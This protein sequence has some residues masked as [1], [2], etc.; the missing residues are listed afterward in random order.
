MDKGSG[1][2]LR[3]R[4]LR[5][6][7][8]LACGLIPWVSMAAS[9]E[10]LQVASRADPTPHYSPLVAEIP[11]PDLLRLRSAHAIVVDQ[12]TREI[13]FA[14]DAD[15]P[16]PIASITKLM[17]AMVNLDAELDLDERITITDGDVDTL[18]GTSS[19]LHIGDAYTRRELLNLALMASENRAASALGRS[20]PGGLEAFVQAMNRKARAIGMRNSHFVEPTGLSSENQSTARDLARMVSVAHAYPLI[21]EL[22]TRVDGEFAAAEADDARGFRNTNSLVRAGRWDIGLSKTGFIR[23]A[24]FCLVMQA[25]I[26]GRPVL[27]AMLGAQEKMSRIGDANRIRAWLEGLN[28]A[29][30]DDIV[31]A[32]KL[33]L[34]KPG[35]TG[36]AAKASLSG[37]AGKTAAATLKPI[38][39]ASMRITPRQTYVLRRPAKG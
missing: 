15:S 9:P 4:F 27:M 31:P 25:D 34:A 11:D 13:L 5:Q 37:K 14:K 6:A 10:R 2:R 12:N 21:R 7:V 19:R 18:K 36:K 17:T 39:G 8:L 3:P 35:R 33:Q 28:P 16:T 20:Y 30:V 1:D 24:G 23:E 38:K 22:S 32:K 26:G 29:A